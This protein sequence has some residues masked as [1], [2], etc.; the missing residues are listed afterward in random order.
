MGFIFDIFPP[1]TALFYL[2]QMH[3]KNCNFFIK[4]HRQNGKYFIS[5]MQ[6]KFYIKNIFCIYF[7]IFAQKWLFFIYFCGFLFICVCFFAKIYLYNT[8]RT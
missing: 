7:N 8:M 5:A 1:K 3:R 4:K 6:E 2:A